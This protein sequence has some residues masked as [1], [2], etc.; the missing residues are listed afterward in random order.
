MKKDF[1][2]IHFLL[3]AAV[4]A[5]GLYAAA[6]GAP[7]EMSQQAIADQIIANEKAA[8]VA[9]QHKD[10]AFWADHLANDS[11]AFFAE[12]PYLEVDPKTNFL[13][14]FDQMAEMMK[15][16]DTTMYNPRVQVYGDTAVLTY[17]SSVS[18]TMGGQPINYTAKVS[19]V[20]IK[21][22]NTWRVVHAHETVNPQAK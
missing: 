20:Y 17:N 19:S 3:A 14:K 6:T 5:L 11:T 21:Q 13:P 18:A 12:S 4:M 16:M 7:T 10:K 9:W 22:G 15:I 8:T 1:S 2:L